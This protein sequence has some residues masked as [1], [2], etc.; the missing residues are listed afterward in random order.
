MNS[1][2]GKA[3]FSSETKDAEFYKYL[4][5]QLQAMHEELT[6]S[7]E[8]LWKNQWEEKL[9]LTVLDSECFKTAARSVIKHMVR[10][11]TDHLVSRIESLE[12]THGLYYDF[13]SSKKSED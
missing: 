5:E 10:L 2:N 1:S 12:K 6:Q 3:G 4:E 7:M 8:V 13:C 9:F 11:E